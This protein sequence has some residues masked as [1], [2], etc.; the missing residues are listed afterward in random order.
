MRMHKR[1]CLNVLQEGCE[2]WHG[3]LIGAAVRCQQGMEM[4]SGQAAKA[5]QSKD[6]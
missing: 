6:R 2:S 1:T 3:E 4:V 5:F